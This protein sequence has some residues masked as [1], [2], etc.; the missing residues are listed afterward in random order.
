MKEM[1]KL[2]GRYAYGNAETQGRQPSPPSPGCGVTVTR[3]RRRAQTALR[4]QGADRP[5]ATRDA[6]Q[7]GALGLALDERLANWGNVS[8]GRR[9]DARDAALIDAAWQRI[10]EAHKM[11]LRMHYVWRAPREVTCRRLKIRRR[12]RHVLDE[13]L[14]Q[15]KAE[16]WEALVEAKRPDRRASE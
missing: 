8:C 5:I 12:P 14:M 2:K 6:V 4:R 13:T 7:R 9:G 3:H 15:A 1:S 10:G 16:I 11:L